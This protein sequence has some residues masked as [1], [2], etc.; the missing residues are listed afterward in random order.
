MNHL[1]DPGLLPRSLQPTTTAA[2][3]G[4]ATATMGAVLL[5]LLAAT[6]AFWTPHVVQHWRG[7]VPP[8]FTMGRTVAI[9]PGDVTRGRQLFSVHCALCHGEGRVSR[10]RPDLNHLQDADA[11]FLFTWIAYPRVVFPEALMPRIDLTPEQIEDIVA[12]LRA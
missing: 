8:P 1:S 10:E 9:H 5:L 12:Y 11:T 2:A 7:D 6:A 3:R 4:D